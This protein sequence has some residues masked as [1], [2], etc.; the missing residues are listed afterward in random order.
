M[1]AMTKVSFQQGNLDVVR[2][3]IGNEP[4]LFQ[5]CRI[6]YSAPYLNKITIIARTTTAIF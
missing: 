4:V 1:E 3:V 2:Y 5:H 6:C